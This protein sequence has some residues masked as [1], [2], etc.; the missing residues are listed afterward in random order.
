MFKLF[1]Y[2]LFAIAI[3]SILHYTPHLE[4]RRDHMLAAIIIGTAILAILDKLVSKSEG[5]QEISQEM[6][7]EMEHPAHQEM[8]QEMEHPA[9]QEMGQEMEHPAHQEMGQEMEHPA[10]Q[11]MGQEMPPSCNRVP[12]KYNLNRHN[13]DVAD[14]G[15]NNNN[16]NPQ[17]VLLQK[18]QF[19]KYLMGF[20][21]VR[22]VIDEQRYNYDV[23][24]PGYY[25]MN[26]GEFTNGGVPYSKAKDII[27][28]SK[29]QD[30]YNQ[31]NF[32][33]KWTP[34]THLGKA[35]GYLNWEQAY[36]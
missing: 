12:R 31:H 8:G 29:L 9:H 4:L 22:K 33:Y 32:N 7:Q 34:H 5:M 28:A 21:K 26:N 13:E 20:D 17:Q 24:G 2:L 30:L 15:L 10:H 27:C 18:G 19:N 14:T 25:L 36:P 11:E 1:K 3:A 35:R 16:D 6:G 23:H